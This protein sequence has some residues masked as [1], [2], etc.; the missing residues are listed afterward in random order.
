MKSSKRLLERTI[1]S[2]LVLMCI[3]Y[4]PIEGNGVS[5]IKVAGM[6]LTPLIWLHNFKGFSKAFK[7]GLLCAFAI[8]ISIGYNSESF[9]LSTVIYKL[10]FVFMFVM[11]YDLVYYHH[12]LHLE[13]FI[14]FLKRLI[15]WFTMVLIIQQILILTGFRYV[16]LF[17]FVEFIDRGIGSNSLSLEPSHTARI[18]TVVML[19]LLRMFEVKWGKNQLNLSR[20][21]KEN[22]WI[23]I[24]FLWSMLSMGSGTAFVGLAI[25]LIYFVKRKYIVFFFIMVGAIY[26]L[27]PSIKYE[28]V[29]RLK[30]TFE[31]ALTLD[32]QAVIEADHSAAARVVPLVNSIND[33]DIDDMDTWL[34]KGID[35]SINSEYLGEDQLIGG[36]NDYGLLV[37]LL[38]VGFF[39]SFCAPGIL[40]IE[41]LIFLVLLSA[42]IGNFAYVWGILMLLTTSKYFMH[43]GKRINHSYLRV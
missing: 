14:R 2:I 4:I 25:L 29:I 38:F 11:Y 23:I 9:R 30:N 41:Q 39:I 19:V 8:L 12:S 26:L 22:K 21:F 43:N 27:A 6:L 18:L 42:T 36:I 31:A 35:S 24:A 17:N 10:S 32:R 33:L 28:P 40:T 5:F 1:L 20:F 15:I 3:Q 7:W 13:V 34:G 16:P 37:F